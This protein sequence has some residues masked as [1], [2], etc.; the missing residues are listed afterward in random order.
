MYKILT[1]MISKLGEI[2]R[3]IKPKGILIAET[4]YNDFQTYT[5]PSRVNTGDAI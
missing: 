4:R 5:R 3:T 1:T 2:C